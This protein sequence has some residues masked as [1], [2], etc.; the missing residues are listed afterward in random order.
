MYCEAAGKLV[1]ALKERGL[2]VTAAESCTGGKIC[3]AIVSV[4]GASEVFKEGFVT[5]SDR[6]KINTIGV[7]KEV[8]E[9]SGAISFETAEYMARGAALKAGAEVAV[10]VT[11][12]AG[13]TADE[14]K[15][16]GLVYIGAY[17]KGETAAREFRFEGDREDIRERAKLCALELLPE[18]ISEKVVEQEQ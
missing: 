4:P 3:D 16:V 14:G 12:N 5:Y 8:I 18:W 9:K 7:P 11:G 13:P 1:K 15:P 17:F 10:S 2:T 6:A